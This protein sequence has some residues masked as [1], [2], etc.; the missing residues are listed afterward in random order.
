VI[1]LIILVA[2]G[3]IVGYWRLPAAA[4]RRALLIGTPLIAWLLTALLMPDRSRPPDRFIVA[5]LLVVCEIGL[6]AL[7]AWTITHR[8]RA[9]FSIGLLLLVGLFVIAKW[10]ETWTALFGW[11][12]LPLGAWLG[13]SFIL[14]RL[15]HVLLE[16]R[17]NQLPPTRFSDLLIY[18]LFPP[19]LIAGP[20]DRLPRFQSDLDR[21]GQAYRFEFL[22]EGT[23]RILIGAFKKFVIADVL[24]RLPLLLADYPGKTSIP[25]LWLMLYAYGFMLY[26]D[27]SGYTDMALG[28]ARLIGFELPENFS[29]PY[30]KTNL[31]RFWQSWHM[32]LSSWARDYVFLPLARTLRRRAEW[33]PA[34]F[35]ALLC[36]L[37]T[38]LVIG[39]WHGFSW[40][41]VAWGV[42]H[43][44]GLFVVK[45]WG[46]WRRPRARRNAASRSSWWN[47][48]AWFLTFNYVMLGW[49]FFSARDLPSALTTLGRLFGI[50]L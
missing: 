30:L 39:L 19:S 49:V 20:I 33:V 22:A 11:W 43:G 45:L 48:P 34:N 26:F 35:V 6:I 8:R 38:M 24:A 17:K 44:V 32:T 31:A 50:K 9:A 16:A 27:F 37:S 21:V 13:L 7:V 3:L 12:A 28:V 1:S 23:W 2:A 25:V 18:T 10:P 46:D 15:L 40:T 36:H 42:W 29:A 4:R 41:F 14:F 5:A 47:L